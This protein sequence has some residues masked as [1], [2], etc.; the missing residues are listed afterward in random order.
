MGYIHKLLTTDGTRAVEAMQG[1]KFVKFFG[2]YLRMKLMEKPLSTFGSALESPIE[3]GVL[4]INAEREA[5]L[6]VR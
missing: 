3:G 4:D 2:A 6:G 1:K 5:S